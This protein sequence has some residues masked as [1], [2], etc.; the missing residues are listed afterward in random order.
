MIKITGVVAM[1][2]AALIFTEYHDF[3]TTVLSLCGLVGIFGILRALHLTKMTF[4]VIWGIICVVVIGLNNLFY[5][6][7]E[8]IDYLPIIQL[9]DF[10]LVLAWTIALNLKMINKN[11][12]QQSL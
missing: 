4:F 11:P 12:Q 10:I 1:V 8:F 5:Y 2:S 3:M 9:L 7:E 6:K